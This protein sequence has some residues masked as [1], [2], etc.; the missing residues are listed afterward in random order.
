MHQQSDIPILSRQGSWGIYEYKPICQTQWENQIRSEIAKISH[1]TPSK[2]DLRPRLVDTTTGMSILVDSGACI[3][4]W[5]KNSRQFS[6]LAPDTER[7]LQAVNGTRIRTFGS[8]Y[9]TIKPP[10]SSP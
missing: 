10:N 2:T 6:N 7:H 4:I 8:H 3:S 5:P 9:L 1:P